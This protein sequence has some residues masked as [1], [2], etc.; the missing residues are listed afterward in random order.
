MKRTMSK[1]LSIALACVMMISL[2]ACGSKSGSET[3]KDKWW[4]TT[5]ELEKDSNGNVVF[6]NVDVALTTIVTGADETVFNKLVAQFNAEYAGKIHVTMTSVAENSIDST[7]AS[8]IT[9]NSNAPDLIMSHQKR[10]NSLANQKL[11]QPFDEVFEQSGIEISMSDFSNNMAEH[12][13]LGYEDSV[14]GIPIDAQ[15]CVV[16]YNKEL[17]N[18]YGGEIP[19]SHSELIALC[20]KVAE[21]EGILPIAMASS[22]S[23]FAEYVFNT[24]VLQNGGSF[25]GEDYRADWYD[26][27]TNRKAIKDALT[28]IRDLTEH[29]P[30]LAA[31]GWGVAAA[32]NEFLNNKALFYISLPWELNE[33]IEGYAS[34]NGGTVESV[35]EEKIG[36]TSM[37]NWFALEEGTEAGKI[38][39][40]D[41]HF[42][43]MSSTVKK[44]EVKAAI[45]EFIR[46]FTTNAEAGAA[47]A[48]AGHVSV[49]TVILTDPIYN[50][51]E[52]VKNYVNHFYSDMNY[53]Q[54]LGVTPY[55][56]DM[57]EALKKLY[58]DSM[59]DGSSGDE[60]NIK[61]AQDSLNTKIDFIG[62]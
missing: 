24:A 3:N 16:F 5:G 43:A 35:K 32:L 22:I 57:S 23:F 36:V 10:L 21:G 59:N 14:M 40:G 38:I 60:D 26:N 34:L 11:L 25:Y 29:S 47:W 9:N 58:V 31:S 17:L 18:K 44:A 42:F 46:W 27:E 62:M 61:E 55:F 6:N 49:S 39:Y 45:C 20:E 8:Q 41:S 33:T 51:N 48:E 28:S 52:F 19:R 56:K 4:E 1:L 30:Q 2:T 54:C 7:L 50:S 13:G 15:S 37:A 53:F 12:V